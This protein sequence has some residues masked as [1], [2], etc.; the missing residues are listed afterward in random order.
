ML[1]ALLVAWS[2]LKKLW[3]YNNI[4]GVLSHEVKAPLSRDIFLDRKMFDDYN[5]KKKPFSSS[6]GKRRCEPTQNDGFS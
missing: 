2:W 6:I 5:P 3:K 4:E 1:L